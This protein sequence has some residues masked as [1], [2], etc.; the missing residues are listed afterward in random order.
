MARSLSCDCFLKAGG[1]LLDVRSPGE[2]A[3]GHIPGAHNLPLFSDEERAA[4]GT[5]YARRGRRAAVRHG[6]ELV[7]P[8]LAA[9]AEQAA[10]LAAAEASLRM[11]CWRGGLRSSSTAWLLE[12][13]DLPCILLDGGY[14]AFRRWLRQALDQPRPVVLLGGHTG[15]GKTDVLHALRSAGAQT[16]DLEG[17]ARHRG[18]SFGGLGQPCQPTT[19]Q[20]ENDIAMALQAVSPHRVLWIEAESV[21]VGRCRIPSELFHQMQQAPL[22]ELQR[23]E[24]ERLDHLLATYGPMPRQE[25]M[26]ATRRIGKRLG[27]QRTQQA[28]EAVAAGNLRRACQVIL[29]YYD[30]TYAHGLARSPHTPVPLVRTGESSTA[31]AQRLL[32]MEPTLLGHSL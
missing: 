3:R 12:T 31:V 11:H 17:L 24:Q 5:L 1:P 10:A 14:K 6:L 7:G 20:F 13:Y 18:S 23:P 26:E 2:F 15:S 19:E 30:R 21:Q 27:P 22:V 28:V 4:V 16:L 8:R 9:L 29:D 32:A 25:L